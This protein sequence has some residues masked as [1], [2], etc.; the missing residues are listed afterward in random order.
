[1][2]GVWNGLDLNHLSI[3][4]DQG[5]QTVMWVHPMEFFVLFFLT[6]FLT[7]TCGGFTNYLLLLPIE[8]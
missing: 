1:M 6:K 2:G 8:F 3:G 5:L 4:T 7:Y